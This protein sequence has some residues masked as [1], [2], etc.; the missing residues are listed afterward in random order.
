MYS[1]KLIGKDKLKGKFGGKGLLLSG[2]LAGGQF[3]Q[4]AGL[5]A[6]STSAASGTSVLSSLIDGRVD[7]AF[8]GLLSAS[9][10]QFNPAAKKK[11]L[12]SKKPL[13]KKKG[14]KHK[15]VKAGLPSKLQVLNQALGMG[16]QAPSV[17]GQSI[18]AAGDALDRTIG[19][20]ETASRLG[21]EG[22]LALLGKL[23]CIGQKSFLYLHIGAK[24]SMHKP[25]YHLQSN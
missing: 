1:G 3:G 4:G 11:G 19:A 23:N 12:F 22:G 17:L 25:P 16:Q 5:G 7:E 21:F 8:G 13:G 20:A 6:S 10:F 15:N 2:A 9:P 14:L 18:S 24:G